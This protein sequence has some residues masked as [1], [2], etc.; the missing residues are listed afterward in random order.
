G[1]G[2][3]AHLMVRDEFGAARVETTEGQLVA[4][5]YER[6]GGDLLPQLL[7]RAQ[8]EAEGVAV[9][10]DRPDADVWGDLGQHL[11]CS[12]EDGVGGTVEHDLLGC[13]AVAGKHLEA[14]PADSESVAGDQAL[15]RWG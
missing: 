8:I 12:Q 3:A 15:K 10:I 2:G 14:S 5:Q 11:V 6:I 13:V 1:D 7:Q 9:R 4:R